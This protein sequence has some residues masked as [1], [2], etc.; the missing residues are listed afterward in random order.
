MKNWPQMLPSNNRLY[1]KALIS[2]LWLKNNKQSISSPIVK[3]LT[4]SGISL[5]IVAGIPVIKSLVMKVL[6]TTDRWHDGTRDNGSR[7]KCTGMRTTGIW[8]RDFMWPE[9][10]KDMEIIH[11]QLIQKRLSFENLKFNLQNTKY[12][13]SMSHH[14][15]EWTFN[16]QSVIYT[17]YEE[18]FSVKLSISKRYVY[19][20][21]P[22]QSIMI[23]SFVFWN[24]DVV[25]SRDNLF[26]L[27][28]ISAK[29]KKTKAKVMRY[30]LF[31]NFISLEV[32]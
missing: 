30:M 11:I 9:R 14:T 13:K 31:C 27:S 7:S 2:V 21:S 15:H 6:M 29:H 24:L 32:Q 16:F 12:K 28:C 3:T 8:L 4:S 26:W 19:I 20:W 23:L 18:L 17:L 5:P 22:S 25:F 1:A 10:S